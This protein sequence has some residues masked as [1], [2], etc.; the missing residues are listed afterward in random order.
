MR[1]KATNRTS[2]GEGTLDSE[3]DIPVAAPAPGGRTGV[4]MSIETDTP[5]TRGCA[6]PENSGRAITLSGRADAE[7]AG[8]EIVLRVVAPGTRTA[9]DLARVRIGGDG[10]FASSPWRPKAL[11]LYQV[12]AV[13]R[14]QDARRTDDFTRP[15]AFELTAP[16]PD[17]RGPADQQRPLDPSR[18]DTTPIPV[19][20]VLVNRSLRVARDGLVRLR[21]HCPLGR[22]EPCSGTIRV[23]IGGRTVGRRTGI[24]MA[25]DTRRTIR[26]RLSRPARRRVER[27]DEVPGKVRIGDHP[28]FA[29]TLRPRR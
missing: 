13:Y 15:L 17:P 19:A 11:G 5:S 7:L 12:A 26:V 29:V 2:E 14:S 8:Q 4:R 27:R 20:P 1:I 10:T 3:S 23:R 22:R 25:R 28:V 9:R 21:L 24:T 6:V 18:Q 16:V